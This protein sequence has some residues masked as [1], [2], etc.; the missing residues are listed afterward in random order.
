MRVAKDWAEFPV[1][2][3]HADRE[4]YRIHRSSHGPLW[5]SA[6]AVAGDGGRFDL[7]DAEGIG[8]CYLTVSAVG[9]F[10]E[11]FGRF[12]VLTAAI[13]QDIG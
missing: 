11:K 7:P 3:V 5:Y 9:A 8:T 10:L 13:I 4:L 6:T 2:R 1:H 12:P